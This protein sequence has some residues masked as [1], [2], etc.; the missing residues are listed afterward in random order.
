MLLFACAEGELEL[1]DATTEAQMQ[2]PPS[3]NGFDAS[4]RF[5]AF[6]PPPVRDA[7][8][9]VQP[10]RV[11]P[12]P[13]D[14]AAQPPPPDGGFLMPDGARFENE[15]D[16]RP[17]PPEDPGCPG[18]S[19][20]PQQPIAI[21]AFDVAYVSFERFE[22]VLLELDGRADGA[23]GNPR[24]ENGRIVGDA[25]FEYTWTVSGLPR[26]EWRFTFSVDEP[27]RQ[28]GVCVKHVQ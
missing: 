1:F 13:L 25:P 14:V 10:D 12:L 11:S 9:Q 5:D 7:V 6:V 24:I 2:P 15:F 23:G 26:G 28:V 18:F 16:A 19:F 3:P 4:M 20:Q 22:R 21:Q 27:P 8:A 17:P